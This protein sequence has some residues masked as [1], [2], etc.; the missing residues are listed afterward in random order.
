MNIPE[1]KYM[2]EVNSYTSDLV[3]LIQNDML[4]RFGEELPLE[5]ENELWNKL[6]EILEK[7]S[8]TGDYR[9][10]N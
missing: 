6:Q 3:G 2:E 4:S 10:Y 7:V 8:E 9:N 5:L 1:L